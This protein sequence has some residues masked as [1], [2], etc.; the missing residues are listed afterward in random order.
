MADEPLPLASPPKPPPTPSAPNTVDEAPAGALAWPPG[1]GP[2][3]RPQRLHARG[4]LGEVHV[5][6]DTELG[7]TV[8]LKR[9]R[10]DRLAEG[11]SLHRF[12]REAEIT[13]RLEHPGIVP[14][15]G[16]VP[17]EDGQ[18]AYAMRFVEGETLK[19]AI[20]H[21]HRAGSDPPSGRRLA[22]RQLLDHFRAAC[23]AVAYA[24]SRGVLHRDL[25]PANVLLG[26]FGE[27]LVV[28]WGL[29]K[30]VGRTEATRAPGESTLATHTAALGDATQHGQAIGTPQ[31]M[32]PE[33]AAGMWQLVGPASDIYSLGATLYHLLTGRPPL[34]D[35]S[36][37][38][39]LFRAQQGEFPRPR[40]VKPG[41][42]RALEAV[43]LKAMAHKP[44]A[45]YAT[46]AALA[47]EVE[48]WL[49]DEPVAAYREA[50]PARLGRWARRH[51]AWAAG[52]AA[53]LLVGVAGLAVATLLLGAKNR[54]LATANEQERRARDQAVT[55]RDRARQTIEEVVSDETLDALSRQKELTAEQRRYLERIVA[56]YQEMTAQEEAAAG[57]AT[58]ALLALAYMRIG[59]GL[60]RLG[61]NPAAEAA[62][63]KALAL[64]E[65]LAAD[66]PTK[67]QYGLGLAASHHNLGM[68]LREL[69]RPA[70]AEAA[71]GRALTLKERL[72]Q[73]FPG[74]PLSR[75]CV[76]NS[77]E[78]LGLLLHQ[79]GRPAE[80]EAVYRRALAL[81]E[82]LATES[83]T[84]PEHRLDL[85]R[86]HSNLG[87]LLRDQGKLAE[88]EPSYRRAL[89]LRERLAAEFPSLPKHGAD[90]AQ[91]HNN[92]GMLLQDLGKPAEAETA[93]RQSLAVFG[94][95]V[96]DFPTVHRYRRDWATVHNNLG[97]LLK[98]VGKTA[99]AEAA[100]RQA[101]A[102]RERL[103]A[104]FPADP[105][106]AVE[107]ATTYV[108]FGNLVRDRGQPAE[109]VSW[110]AKAIATLQP[111]LDREPRL[112]EAGQFLCHA[113]L[114][115]ALAQVQTGQ[116]DR[117]VATAEELA[118]SPQANLEVVYNCA[119]VYAQAAAAVKDPDAIERY[120]ARAVALL[121]E[122]V[123]RGFR[124][125]AHLRLDSDLTPL[126]KRDDFRKVLAELDAMK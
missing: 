65:R 88:A 66:F 59:L 81:Q 39:L 122:A 82:R 126:R 27:T 123:A 96:A 118:R 87:V 69:G 112:L 24:H 86:I 115:L 54:E 64:H 18:P 75:L 103:A 85:A 92:L 117:A 49:A 2:R 23:L 89:A 32:S 63:R 109:S 10:P 77:H 111:V 13:A 1:G 56:Y 53:A 61:Q 78:G 28:D 33:Q 73:D 5:A 29:A 83:P 62:Y 25:K 105:D 26:K 21:Y 113:K 93:Y 121:R 119:C 70:E 106:H 107:L 79:L 71:L 125:A 11:G 67:P 52:L 55:A 20:D 80:A 48:H 46:A 41:V 74:L 120:A 35:A 57:E 98:A 102:V 58:R 17:D 40:Q 42:P 51:R 34:Q 9:V 99:E 104:E 84:V 91:S 38:R 97:T 3:Y 60:H 22:F 7:R 101:L 8:A 43:C 45:R 16:L 4:G 100:Y 30:V 14:V 6:A 44:E 37:E 72:A 124:N 50:W 19:E 94:R 47:A 90:L 95:L 76:A 108:N 116:P 31:Y 15:H 110:Y 36:L 114:G 12:L 68:L